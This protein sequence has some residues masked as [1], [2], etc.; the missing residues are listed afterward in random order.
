MRP[1]LLPATLSLLV[2]F[3]LL[4]FRKE[5]AR[6]LLLPTLALEE[7]VPLEYDARPLE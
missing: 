1:A 7:F 4:P 2:P 6:P 5:V 3:A